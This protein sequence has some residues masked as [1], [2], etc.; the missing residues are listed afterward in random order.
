MIDLGCVNQTKKK[1][2]KKFMR[3]FIVKQEKTCSINL[4]FV[5]KNLTI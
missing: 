2:T 1:Q 3:K 4:K 5:I